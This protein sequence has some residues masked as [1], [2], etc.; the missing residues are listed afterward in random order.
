VIPTFTAS[1]KLVGEDAV[2]SMT[3][4]TLMRAPFVDG[5]DLHTPPG[6]T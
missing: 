3:F 4:A 1:A 2:I 5:R 6:C